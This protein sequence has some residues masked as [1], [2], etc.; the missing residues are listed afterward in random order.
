MTDVEELLVGIPVKLAPAQAVRARGER[1]RAQQRVGLVTA[2]LIALTAAGIGSWTDLTPAGPHG[3]DVASEGEN[4]FMSHGT[5]RNFKHS[6]LPMHK[7]LNWKVDDKDSDDETSQAAL[8]QAGLNGVCN[9]SPGNIEGPQQQFTS[10]FTGKGDAK[11]RYRVSQYAN[12]D[13]ALDAIR[14]LGQ[15]LRDCGLKEH[16]DGSYSGMPN[17]N[18]PRLEVS[19]RHWKAWVGVVEAQYSTT[20]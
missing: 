15:T 4:P 19:V 8:P 6:D 1:R 12:T 17:G 11:A 16:K 18:G 20:P 3:S 10:A 9:G 5:V 2:A 14:G 7:V 13:Q